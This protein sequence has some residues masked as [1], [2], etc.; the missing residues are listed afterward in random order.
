[1]STPSA[2]LLVAFRDW[3]RKSALVGLPE[4]PA[5]STTMK[6]Q[7][8]SVCWSVRNHLERREAMENATKL[9]HLF[10]HFLF[11]EPT[12]WQP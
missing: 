11:T 8:S 1:M 4:A 10:K 5:E 9:G 7:V 2:P 3:R 6:A 12:A